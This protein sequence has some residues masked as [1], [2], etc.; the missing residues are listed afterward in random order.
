MYNTFECHFKQNQKLQSDMTDPVSGVIP[1]HLF[2][3]GKYTELGGIPPKSTSSS[4]LV[5]FLNSRMAKSQN[6]DKE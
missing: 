2:W 4:L 3:H 5:T 1:N 6:D